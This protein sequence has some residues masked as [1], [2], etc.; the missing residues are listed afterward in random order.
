MNK[1][2]LT[3][4]TFLFFTSLYSL[5][6]H[7][8]P[9]SKRVFYTNEER[10][11]EFLYSRK[12]VP[13]VLVG[14]S[15]SGAF[16][17]RRLFDTPYFNL[18]LPFAGGSTGLEIIRKSNRFPKILFFETNHSDRAID[19]NLLA[20]FFKNPFSELKNRIPFLLKKNKLLNNVIDRLKQPV[21]KRTNI[22]QPPALL[23]ASLLAASIKEWAKIADSVKLRI[24]LEQTKP[25]KI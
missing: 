24:Q 21:E 14:S 9:L 8:Y 11:E 2:S 18:F 6:L 13:I 19:S 10:I 17:G 22:D 25:K 7:I 1:I 4:F 15:L 3:F 20:G 16:E 12:E 5:F 23:Y